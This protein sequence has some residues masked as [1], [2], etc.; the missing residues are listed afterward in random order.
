MQLIEIDPTRP[1]RE[2]TRTGGT[3]RRRLWAVTD[4]FGIVI[5]ASRELAGMLDSRPLIGRNLLLYLAGE[6]PEVSAALRKSAWTGQVAVLS[7]QIR[8]RERPVLAAILHVVPER[9]AL[10]VEWQLQL[11][12]DPVDRTTDF[13]DAA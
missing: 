12:P 6:R 4:V 7:V 11:A 2:R 9:G 5:A 8:P 3:R 13:D 1:A 10:N